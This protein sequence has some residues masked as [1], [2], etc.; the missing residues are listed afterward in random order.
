MKNK[1]LAA[2]LATAAA[3]T[4]ACGMGRRP[5]PQAQ[6]TTAT[7][8]P[9]EKTPMTIQE[10]KGQHG[11]PAEAGSIVAADQGAW[12]RAWKQVG[13]DA[14]ALDFVKF[15]GVIVFVGEK[16]TGGWSPVFDEPVAKGDDI[17]VR[18]RVPKPTGFT[19]Q[20]FTQPWKARAYPRPKGRVIVEAAPE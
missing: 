6:Q 2:A 15:V 20:A 3:A 19:T 11:G 10:W 4:A 1:I 7:A 9:V 18:Y 8:A 13:Q 14:P 17:V 16:P 12:Q 5:S